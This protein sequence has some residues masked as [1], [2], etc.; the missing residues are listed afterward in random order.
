MKKT[1][2]GRPLV[3]GSIKGEA[4]VSHEGVN[5]LASWKDAAIRKSKTAVCSDQNNKDLY[6][7][8]LDG[9]VLCL[10]Q[11]IGSTTG[12]I[13]LATAAHL[14]I[15]PAALLFA[16]HI[17]SLAASGIIISDIWVG[18]RIV[19]IDCLGR[20]FLDFT[21]DGMTVDIEEDGTV[22]VTP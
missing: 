3:P 18:N 1:F 8:R 4:L 17:D 14:N 9:R 10:P 22:T 15:G 21:A 11:V 7:K 12:G 2:K 6:N 19:T 5:P 20:D 13:V 16:E